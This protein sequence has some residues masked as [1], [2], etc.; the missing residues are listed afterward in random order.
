MPPSA[1]RVLYVTS[2]WDGP[3]RYRCRHAVLQ[4]R[5]AGTV[6]D[7]AS[8]DDAALL[9]LAPRYS[10]VVL[11]RLPW[12][13][14]VADVCAAARA[15]GARLA[16]ESDDLIFD[17]SV[18]PLVHFLP[19]LPPVVRTEYRQRFTR[20][21]ATF[22]ACH[23]FVG[24]TPSLVRLAERLRKPAV[25]HPNLL[26]DA[27]V[28]R[29]TVI[30][31]LARLQPRPPTLAYVSGSN[32]HDRDF[33]T[34]VEPLVRVLASA[35][36]ARLFVCG[37]LDLPLGLRRFGE[38]IVRVPYLDWR[39]YPWALAGCR[40]ALAPAA[41]VNEFTDA[42][43]VLKFFEAGVLGVPVVATPT[44]PF[45][46]AVEH[47]RNGLLAATPSEWEHALREV[48]DGGRSRAL[49]AAARR[50]VLAQHTTRAHRGRLAALLAPHAGTSSGPSPD[51]RPLE[52]AAH[53]GPSDEVAARA[54]RVR[55]AWALLRNAPPPTAGHEPP[56]EPAWQ[57][58]VPPAR[59]DALLATLATHGA[60]WISDERP[61][62]LDLGD[63]GALPHLE[64]ADVDVTPADF[65]W[66]V[67]RMRAVTDHLLP[68]A[69]FAW[70]SEDVPTFEP[71][72]AVAWAIEADGAPRTYAI[73]LS[74]SVWSRTERVTRLRL[75]VLDAPGGVAVDAVLLAADLAQLVP[76]GDLRGPL[77]ERYLRGVGIE[78]G[79]LQ[80]P[81]S[82]SPSA[83]VLYVD[84]LTPAQARAHYPELEGQPLVAPHVV[85]DVQRLPVGDAR[86]D[87]CIGNHL[88]EHARDPIAAV[89]ELL[90]IV[91]PGGV[92]YVSV[93]DVGNPLDRGRPVTPFAHLL[94]DHDP[95]AD[96]RAEDAAHYREYTD[97]AHP[98]LDE[99]T[100][101]TVEARF[102]AQGYSI[103]FH[104][105]DEAAFH[106][107]LEHVT[108]VGGARLVEFARNPG[109]DFDEHVAVLRRTAVARH[110]D[111]TAPVDVIVPIYEAR[112]ETIA[113]VESVL[114]H[115]DGDWRLVLV[116]DASRDPALVDWL[117]RLAAS[118]A[119]VT[120]L[121]NE[122]NRGFVQ[123]ANRG[124]RHAGGRDVLLLNSD[125]V[126]TAGFL[127]GLR[128]A[129]YAD[130]TTG[131]VSP[132]S[133]NATVC[134][135]PDHPH[136]GPIPDGYTVD[137]FGDLI[138]RTSLRLRPELPTAVGFCMYVRAE[139]LERVG[140]FDAERF[141]RGYGEE[142][143]LC[144]RALAA[145]FGVRL[146]DDVFVYHAGEASFGAETRALRTQ[147]D[148][149]LEALHPGYF[150]KVARYIAASRLAPVH[151]NLRLHMRRA[152]RAGEPALLVLLH[153]AFEPPVGG[154]EHHVRDLLSTLALPRAVVA[155]PR[156][157]GIHVTE[158]LDG[159]L[160]DAPR[161]LFPLATPPERFDR[162]R[163]D[164]EAVLAR[165]VSTFGVG[166]VHVH[167][168]LNWPTDLASTLTRLGLRWV[169]TAH[170]YYCVCPNLN[171]VDAATGEPC[172]AAVGGAA[173]D[174]AACLR[175]LCTGLGLPPFADAT[176][177][178][179]QHRADFAALLAGADAIVFPSHAA[180]E[181]VRRFHAIDD[182]RARVIPHGAAP[183]VR[184]AG[185]RDPH[186][187]LRIALLGAVAY[188]IKGG[189]A[190]PELIARTRDLP[191]EW[192][193]FGDAEGF[194]FA[195]RLRRAGAGN[196]LV[197]H[198]RYARREITALLA[199]A[200]I[201]VVVL[202]P[203]WPE[204]FSYTLSEAL[205]TG[206]P[207][208][209]SDQGALAERLA[210]SDAGLVVANVDEAAAALARLANDPAMLAR[211]QQAALRV[212][213]RSLA[214]MAADYRPIVS[215]L[216][217][218][219]ARPE[220][221]SLGAR[222]E[223][224]VAADRAA[225]EPREVQPPPPVLSHYDRWWYPV[226]ERIAA[227]VPLAFRRWARARI[228]ERQWPTVKT[229]RFD[230]RAATSGL[231]VLP[232]NGGAH[233]FRACDRDPS[234]VFAPE[235]IPTRR[236]RIVRFEMRTEARG[237]LYAQLFW[238]H[239]PEEGFS[240]E[241][242]IHI[243]LDAAD[244]AWHEYTLRVD[245]TD[246]GAL[247]DAGEAIRRLR[248]DP[249]NAPG[250]IE[251]R[252][253]RLC[254]PGR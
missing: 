248:F 112:A 160:A 223:L 106:R 232:P 74:A 210:G 55:Q 77:A 126:V 103:H 148:E 236:A 183:P 187:S 254:A 43:S 84:R 15:G 221:L 197:L 196:R 225:H 73:D 250:V 27:A 31:A 91:R 131:I 119:R 147:N 52:P 190:Y 208:I 100:R 82:T 209:A 151:D 75:D 164:V 92:L 59:F 51:P 139:V 16:F 58:P 41:V 144:E 127:A 143:D 201:D 19:D 214:D 32:T 215:S 140:L 136:G 122:E 42:K 50:T 234:F 217:G 149:T 156:S 22:D 86:V 180:R 249:L 17:P 175:T 207:V 161:Y 170:D 168:L 224:F 212:E 173:R 141:P 242:S 186:A 9:A 35:G 6:A 47:G 97:S 25:L 237:H 130:A 89:E 111:A 153:D 62:V 185:E 125:T 218:T 4:L 67:V 228:A 39:V 216:L 109:A 204:T 120:L 203:N 70:A 188:P 105:F 66:L 150:A 12:S 1:L 45:R 200:G 8:I 219:A 206:V 68:A 98:Q 247:W 167:H 21:R 165:V 142:N 152:A 63:A 85:G 193:V 18:E 159:E 169:V 64:R 114:R 95:G 2:C 146:A 40:A 81:L 158:V 3:Y 115:A 240:E 177:T 239:A 171:L 129:V 54:D 36:D 154:T 107:L 194:G 222:R 132:L 37:H 192:H 34:V 133:N 28:R 87:F 7:V 176:T 121:R 134:S 245:D 231:E 24:S 241:K 157:D 135:V 44:E 246:R 238:A 220:P 79:A 108:A 80:K 174:S 26:D 227:L 253:L 181:V 93:P 61:V 205:L 211:M 46:A 94:D 48:L 10:L 49:G 13:A 71:D 166:A 11:F 189:D 172:C 110:A 124:M 33:E 117:D 29:A 69:R 38:R 78:C 20:L 182:A 123:T 233:R 83:R 65:R 191:I 60:G 226:Y 213:H 243:P 53:G 138:A 5:D 244:G 57:E 72:C 145:G 128:R 90:R 96:R 229:L 101:R 104:T 116:D 163:P 23:V 195:E 252:E 56:A 14:R 198:G 199:D 202:L 102:L 76:D 30:R 118:D 235:P 88:L 184:R 155:V 230:R 179:A 251:L 99:A 137:T 178:L 162:W 113:C